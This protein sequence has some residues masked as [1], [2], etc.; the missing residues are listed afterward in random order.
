MSGWSAFETTFRRDLSMTR[1]TRRT[2]RNSASELPGSGAAGSGSPAAETDHAYSQEDLCPSCSVSLTRDLKDDDSESW[3]RCDFCKTWY[4]WRCVG[5]NGQLETIDKWFCGPCRAADC[6]RVI[7]L[8]PPMRKSSRNR[9]VHDY[10]NLHSGANS[11]D[12]RRWSLLLESK[13]FSKDEFKRMRGSDL[14]EEW[15]YNDATA[16]TE[17]VIIEKPDGLGMM[18]PP[19]TLT[20]P[21]IAN[22]L[23]PE[24]PLEVIDVGTQSSLSGWTLGKWASYY[25]TEPS[26]REKT[27]NVISLEISGTKLGEQVLPP[28]LVRDIDWVEKFW[29]DNRKGNSHPYPKVQLYCLMGVAEAW[30]DWHIDF[31]GSSVYYHILK[32]SK[33][34]LFIRPTTT[35]LAS[36]ERWSGSEIQSHTWLGDMVDEVTKVDLRE[37]NTMIIPTGWIHAVYTPQDALVFGGNFLHSYNAALQL[38]VR[39]IEIATH[40]PKKFRF[41]LFSRLCWY[42]GEKYLRDL[43]AKEDFAPR[44]LESIEVLS[45]FLVSEVRAIERGPES[46]RRD[47]RDQVPNDK[48]KDAP[49]VARELRWRVRLA[50]GYTSDG[51]QSGRF[52]A[53]EPM[54]KEVGRKRKRDPEF[55]GVDSRFRNFQPKIW[56]ALAEEQEEGVRHLTVQPTQDIGSLVEGWT[57]W[58]EEPIRSQMVNGDKVEVGRR[59]QVIVKTRRTVHG[60]ERQ[61]VERVVETWNWDDVGDAN[62]HSPTGSGAAETVAA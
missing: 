19:S 26:S 12:P 46:L 38:R 20:V 1:S 62:V 14:T 3:V 6:R 34:F 50:Q 61:R 5:E 43:R 18:M 24:T 9:P 15:L 56:E 33:T 36:Y 51:D 59:R 57:D 7:T 22:I 53:R 37:G 54:T 2:T 13:T 29:P 45:D 60:F 55:S 10:V 35:N 8:K 41:P 21:D 49:A 27:R 25:S 52:R 42:V 17:P 48:V 28:R 39:E 40:V 58:K 31:A 30:T 4:H 47:V 23:G 32:G 16:M 44:V 11:S